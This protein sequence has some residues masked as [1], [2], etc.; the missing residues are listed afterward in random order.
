MF[1]IIDPDINI[2]PEIVMSLAIDILSTIADEADNVPDTCVRA[3]SSTI[4][5]NVGCKVRICVLA[6]DIA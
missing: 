2:D 3:D 5:P 4:D 6:S 1:G